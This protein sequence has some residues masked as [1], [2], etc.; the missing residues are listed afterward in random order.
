M[1][2]RSI[3][4]FDSMNEIEPDFVYYDV[5]VSSIR[6]EETGINDPQV[7]FQETRTQPIL[8]DCSKYN[9][10]II[11][12]TMD[13]AGSDLPMWIPTIA[14]PTTDANVTVYNVSIVHGTTIKT[15]PLV[16]TSEISNGSPTTPKY[17]FCYTY[18]HFCDM[19]NTAIANAVADVA[20]SASVT[21]P[22]VP[23][24]IYN[25]S[26]NLFSLY[27]D[28]ASWDKSLGLWTMYFD[29]NLYQLLRN[30]NN[31]YTPN[32]QPLTNQIIIQNNLNNTFTDSDASIKYL[33]MTQDYPSTDAIWSPIT[34]LVFT[35]SLLPI[36]AE[37]LGQPILIGNNNSSNPLTSQS[38]FQQTITDIAL[39]LQRSADYKGFVEYAPYP[40]RMISLSPARAEVRQIDISVFYKDRHGKLFPVTLANGASVSLKIMFRHKRLGI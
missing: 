8:T 25:G 28:S 19:F 29:A 40:Y 10:S 21:T 31:V 20:K 15:A 7:R 39:P 35:S 6:T 11:R 23:K 30:F 2:S 26:T 22:T 13:G 4:N 16:W 37:Q 14:D 1:L 33:V 36:V 9:M 5:S 27:C 34:S 32:N 3:M 12:F 38:N 17:Y 24:L 18:S